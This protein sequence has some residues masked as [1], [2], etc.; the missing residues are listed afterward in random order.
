MEGNAIH[1]PCFSLKGQNAVVC[2]ANPAAGNPGFRL[3]LT[4]KL[5][6]PE[7]AASPQPNWAWLVQ[8][9]DH[10]LCAPFTGTRPFLAGE[11]AFYS[12]DSKNDQTQN[13]L[14]GD[15]DNNKPVWIAKK[16]TLVKSGS[17]WV[18]Q[19]SQPVLILKV[20]Q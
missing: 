17:D 8:L 3:D 16:A 4:G 5:P 14:L 2:G 12:C 11:I 13:L 18:I 19:S 10:T 6:P 20:W 7:T 9:N 1:D 15:L